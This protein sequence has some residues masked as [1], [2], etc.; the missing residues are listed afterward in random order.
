MVETREV[1]LNDGYIVTVHARDYPWITEWEWRY[2]ESSGRVSRLRWDGKTVYLYHEMLLRHRRSDYFVSLGE[3]AIEVLF[4]TEEVWEA[5]MQKYE[6]MKAF[7]K[8]NNIHLPSPHE[9][10]SFSLT[11]A[12]YLYYDW[13]QGG[14]EYIYKSPN[15]GEG[16]GKLLGKKRTTP[17]EYTT[18]GEFMQNELTGEW[19]EEEDGSK[20]AETYSE[21][22][23]EAIILNMD[24]LFKA[25]NPRSNIE[26]VWNF[27]DAKDHS[28]DDLAI[29]IHY[30][31]G[32]YQVPEEN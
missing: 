18:L 21:A 5:Y 31:I 4:G 19:A 23:G 16:Q 25:A 3:D 1:T 7:C 27:L 32:R 11:S 2:E 10:V 20:I 9:M 22:A 6:E 14:K 29:L 15:S 8:T 26:S 12:L 30:L 13:L 17:V 24:E 28:I